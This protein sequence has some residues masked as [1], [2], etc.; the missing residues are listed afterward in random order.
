MYNIL[1]QKQTIMVNIYLSIKNNDKVFEKVKKKRLNIM[2]TTSITWYDKGKKKH[3][4]IQEITEQSS[5]LG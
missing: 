1:L 5:T 4:S 3:S 2:I